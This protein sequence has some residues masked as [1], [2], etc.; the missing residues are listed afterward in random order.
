M[1]GEI[2]TVLRM[3]SRHQDVALQQLQDEVHPR[4]DQREPRRYGRRHDDRRDR[5]EQ[6]PDQRDRFGER[7]D[8]PEQEWA[9]H[10]E[11]GVRDG[12]R[13]AHRAHQDQL[14]ANPTAEAGL[15]LVPDIARPSSAVGGHEGQGVPLDARM[16]DEPEV[17]HGQQVTIDATVSATVRPTWTTC[18]VVGAESTGGFT[19]LDAGVDQRVDALAESHR[20]DV[21]RPVADPIE[22][23]RQQLDRR[24]ELGDRR[25]QATSASPTTASRNAPYTRRIVTPRPSRTRPRIHPIMGSRPAARTTEMNT[26]RRA[27]CGRVAQHDQPY[28]ERDADGE[29]GATDE[30]LGQRWPPFERVRHADLADGSTWLVRR[31]A[32]NVRANGAASRSERGEPVPRRTATRRCSCDRSRYVRG[33]ESLCE[34]SR[35]S[36]L[37]RSSLEN[38]HQ[39]PVDARLRAV[40][41]DT[42]VGRLDAAGEWLPPP[43]PAQCPM[44]APGSRGRL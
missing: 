37:W 15:D 18:P 40:S 16:L 8:Q 20:P 34:P 23:R 29:A 1:N 35:P 39:A 9:G 41:R 28:H 11:D 24:L 44:Y 6:R 7:G 3:T 31:N 12:R 10:A 21:G 2:P 4:Y 14:A 33:S 27:S 17:D 26:S 13:E 22:E 43:V 30:P 36:L 5:A 42:F 19:S 32:R 38:R 25:R